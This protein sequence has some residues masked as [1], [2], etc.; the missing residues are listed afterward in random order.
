MIPTE[1]R[2]CGINSP[3]GR[4]DTSILKVFRFLKLSINTF[5]EKYHVNFCGYPQEYLGKHFK[6]SDVKLR[7]NFNQYFYIFSLHL[8][9]FYVKVLILPIHKPLP[10]KA[11][12]HS[13]IKRHTLN[14]KK[15]Q[16]T[17]KLSLVEYH[18]SNRPQR[19]LCKN[20]LIYKYFENRVKHL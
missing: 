7:I 11:K 1:E 14:D 13:R 20:C 6:V 18:P 17:R 15:C 3:S 12:L 10:H 5:L 2:R 4:R 16:N 8:R 19:S 9:E